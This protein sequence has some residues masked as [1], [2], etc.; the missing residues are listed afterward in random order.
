MLGYFCKTKSLQM[1]DPTLVAFIRSLEIVFGFVCQV[2]ILHQIP[3]VLSLVGA[4]FVLTSVLAISLQDILMEYIPERVR[5]I[6]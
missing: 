5:F 2:A 6:F 1:I 3:T 4:G